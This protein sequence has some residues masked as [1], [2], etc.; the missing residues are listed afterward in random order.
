MELYFM[1]FPVGTINEKFTNCLFNQE[2]CIKFELFL[3]EKL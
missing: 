2:F 3:T 1:R